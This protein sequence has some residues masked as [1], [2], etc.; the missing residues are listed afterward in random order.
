LFERRLEEQLA[1]EPTSEGTGGMAVAEEGTSLSTAPPTTTATTP[2]LLGPASYPYRH[3]L[4]YT[5][6]V[7]PFANDLLRAL[8]QIGDRDGYHQVIGWQRDMRERMEPVYGEWKAESRSHKGR[9][10]P[11]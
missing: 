11:S 8:R 6:H 2:A 7:R 1:L 9:N 10:G 3:T 5:K 4:S